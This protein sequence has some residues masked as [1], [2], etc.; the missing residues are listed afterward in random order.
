MTNYDV[1]EPGYS[2]T[3]TEEWDAPQ[4]ADFDTDDLSAIADHFV[5]ST[6]GFPPD[7]FTDL[8][9]S[10]VDPDGDL[11]ENALQTADGGAHSVDA[12]DGID[13]ET[14]AEVEERLETLSR[15][16]FDS[17]LGE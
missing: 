3:T 17:E 4:M 1:H 5:L 16:E 10:V 9:L 13:D 2:G 12:S 6:T 11:T 8:K 7:D 15:E 14:R